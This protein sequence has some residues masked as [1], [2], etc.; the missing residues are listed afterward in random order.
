MHVTNQIWNIHL[1]TVY[2]GYV[3]GKITSVS[4]LTHAL[5]ISIKYP[6]LFCFKVLFKQNHNFLFEFDNEEEEKR[7]K[8]D[9]ERRKKRK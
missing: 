3:I 9:K 4:L 5:K 8:E 1:F 2:Y 7:K 6:Y